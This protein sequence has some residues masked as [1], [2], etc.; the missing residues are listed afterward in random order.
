[1][2]YGW[3]VLRAVNEFVR[4]SDAKAGVVLA[5]AGGSAAFLATK[6][7]TFH[8]VIV[9]HRDAW[10]VILYC[11]VFSYLVS[12]VVTIVCAF[13][14]IWPS[15]ESTNQVRSLIYFRH[16]AEDYGDD[17]GKYADR[18]D[19]CDD[20]VFLRELAHQIVANSQVATKK[21]GWVA[22]AIKSLAWTG[23]AWAVCVL[24][25]LLLGVTPVG[26]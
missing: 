11:A 15:L 22:V 7:D 9:S 1:M 20:A 19:G 14:S 17:H 12:L 23:G 2:K 13:K 8:S 21:F 4:F 18:L 10:G 25:M 5:F 3:D 26:H 24:L 16:I 6:I